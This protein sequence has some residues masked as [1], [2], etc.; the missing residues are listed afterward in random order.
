MN[1]STFRSQYPNRKNSRTLDDKRI[2]CITETKTL[3]STLQ[4]SQH[5]EKLF[6]WKCF[7]R[8]G[9]GEYNALSLRRWHPSRNKKHVLGEVQPILRRRLSTSQWMDEETLSFVVRYSLALSINLSSKALS[10]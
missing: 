4:W 6:A 1:R 10:T 3:H 9:E 7:P 2:S 5:S 8:H